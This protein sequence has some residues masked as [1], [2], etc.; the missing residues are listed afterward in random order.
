MAGWRRRDA[1]EPFRGASALVHVRRGDR[2]QRLLD[3]QPQSQELPIHS[4]QPVELESNR[5]A[6]VNTRLTSRLTVR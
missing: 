3:C 4:R 6:G 2:P 1:M 5:Q